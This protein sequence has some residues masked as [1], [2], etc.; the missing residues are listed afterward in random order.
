MCFKF[1]WLKIEL[2]INNEIAGEIHSV[3]RG[4][5]KLRS[6]SDDLFISYEAS[7]SLMALLL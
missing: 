2:R 1:E 4:I 5:I 7:L 3:F 6:T